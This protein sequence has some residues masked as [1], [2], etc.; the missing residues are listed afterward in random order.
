MCYNTLRGASIQTVALALWSFESP[1]GYLVLI[2]TSSTHPSWPRV[3][4][5][6]DSNVQ[7]RCHSPFRA[8]YLR[9]SMSQSHTT[10]TDTSLYLLHLRLKGFLASLCCAQCIIPVPLLFDCISLLRTFFLFYVCPA[11]HVFLMSRE[12]KSSYLRRLPHYLSLVPYQTQTLLSS[13]GQMY[14]LT[15]TG[16]QQ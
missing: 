14:I 3:T 4:E 6:I 11:S 7:T 16:Y 13:L 12:S 1:A 9:A 5:S 2:L 15:P 8:I 10:A